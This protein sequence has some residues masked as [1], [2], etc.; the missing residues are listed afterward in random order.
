MSELDSYHRNLVLAIT[1]QGDFFRNN[2]SYF[3]DQTFIGK[4]HDLFG[5]TSERTIQRSLTLS[6][7][8][9]WAKKINLEVQ[10]QLGSGPVDKATQ[11]MFAGVMYALTNSK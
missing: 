5:L 7:D 1:N 10:N 4:C 8:K 2:L 11:N 6:D 9:F 3:D